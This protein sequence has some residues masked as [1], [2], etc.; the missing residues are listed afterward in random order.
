MSR[1]TLLILINFFQ[2]FVRIGN[3]LHTSGV[4]KFHMLLFGKGKISH[5]F[6]VYYG[7]Q[8]PKKL[9]RVKQQQDHLS[10]NIWKVGI[11]SAAILV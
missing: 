8:F 4:K 1:W 10:V 6:P 3:T 5:Y 2:H 11:R 9:G 7:P